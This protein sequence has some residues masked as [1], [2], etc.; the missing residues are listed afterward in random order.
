MGHG[1]ALFLTVFV[2]LW[3]ELSFAEEQLLAVKQ[4]MKGQTEFVRH[5]VDLCLTLTYPLHQKMALS[6]SFDWGRL[7]HKKSKVSM[8]LMQCLMRMTQEL[9]LGL[10]LIL[11]LM[12]LVPSD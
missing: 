10:T 11:R 4:E 12:G 3:E 9:V 2:G 5:N 6:F 8:N 1:A 7:I